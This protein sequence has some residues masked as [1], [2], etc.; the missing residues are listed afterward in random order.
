VVPPR[1]K[2]RSDTLGCLHLEVEPLHM[3]RGA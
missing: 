2:L 3:K 1:A